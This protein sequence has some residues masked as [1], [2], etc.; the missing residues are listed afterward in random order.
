MHT[1]A[2]PSVG[3]GVYSISPGGLLSGD[4]GM[5]EVPCSERF[6]PEAGEYRTK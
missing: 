4:P 5:T 1:E 3:N 2:F 6:F